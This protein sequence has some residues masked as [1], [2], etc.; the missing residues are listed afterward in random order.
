MRLSRTN[1]LAH[2]S[3]SKEQLD[4]VAA[5][6][7]GIPRPEMNR[8]LGY[9]KVEGNFVLVSDF[10]APQTPMLAQVVLADGKLNYYAMDKSLLR[11]EPIPPSE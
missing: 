8:V 5:F 3:V 10:V 4:L 9:V 1:N 7:V 2:G 11:S 6:F